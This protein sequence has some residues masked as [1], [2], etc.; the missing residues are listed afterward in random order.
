MLFELQAE[1]PAASNHKFLGT[2]Y[3]VTKKEAAEFWRTSFA[4]RT[5]V[6][7]EEFRCRLSAVHP[8]GVGIETQALKSTIDLTC[9]DHISNFEFDVF[10]RL[11]HPWGTLLKNWQ[12]LAVTHPAY[13]AFLTYEE[14]KTKLQAFINKPGSYVFRLSCTKLGQWAIGYVAPD[15]K[16]YQTIP[17]NKSLIQS[18]VDGSREGL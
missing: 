16:I 5:L 15:K 13:V 2:N 12:L 4:D 1:F 8:I 3:R 9:N 11:F 10:T 6:P 7:W 18:L 17:Q 14:V